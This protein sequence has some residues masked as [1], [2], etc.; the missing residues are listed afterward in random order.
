MMTTFPRLRFGL[1]VGIAGGVP[2]RKHPIRLGDVVVSKPDRERQHGGELNLS[3]WLSAHPCLDSLMHQNIPGVIQYDYGKLIQGEGFKMNGVLNQPPEVILAG[4]GKVRS[5][6]IK[7]GLFMEY[8]SKYKPRDYE[9]ITQDRKLRD[10]LFPKDCKHIEAEE[11]EDSWGFDFNDSRDQLVD[12]D[13]VDQRHEREDEA[14]P[15][16]PCKM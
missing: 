7:S 10:R 15:D 2:S 6:P 11:A 14:D 5:A 16:D 9:D 8:F 13:G 3:L 4:L 12:H 1:L